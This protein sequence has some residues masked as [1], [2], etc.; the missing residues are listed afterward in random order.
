MENKII[1]ITN[2]PLGSD[3][4][5]E[6]T[7]CLIGEELGAEVK[8]MSPED[9]NE[10]PGGLLVLCSDVAV[11]DPALLKRMAQY[12][13]AGSHLI[14]YKPTNQEINTVYRALE[15]RD[16]FSAQ[17]KV[18]GYSL[19]GL[20]L[21]QGRTC[22]ILEGH[23]K[24]SS[25]IARSILDF[26][27]NQI[28]LTPELRESFLGKAREILTQ[29]SGVNLAEMARQYVLTN[30]FTL[31]GKSMSLSYFMTSCHNYDGTDP[32][33]GDD[34]YFIQQTGILNGQNGYEKYWA[35]TRVKVNGGSWYVGQGEVCLNY[36]DYYKMVNTP[37]AQSDSSGLSQHPVA[38]VYAQP[39]SINGQTQ[40]TIS[41]S[42]SL[43]G[44]LGFEGGAD[45]GSL[46]LKGNG[47]LSAGGS[48]DSSYTFTTEDCTCKGTSLDSQQP[49]ASWNYSFKRAS[50]NRSAGHWQRLH[51]PANLAVSVFSPVNTWVWK[52][53]TSCRDQ[54]K[55]FNSTFELGI[56]NTITRYSGSQGPKHIP[57]SLSKE[58][59]QKSMDITL[60]LPPLLAVDQHQLTFSKNCSTKTLSIACQGSWTL[61][62]PT[63]ASW[64]S[65]GD[66][67]T[68]GSGPDT[69]IHIT[70]QE[71]TGSHSRSAILTLCRN[72]ERAADQELLEIKIF[73]S[74]GSVE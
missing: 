73:Q 33:G 64:I 8:I 57:Q 14:L 1:T 35:G 58:D 5:I 25:Q 10:I 21:E 17:A 67:E 2:D 52:I 3:S 61:Q 56:M 74:P 54:F 50:Q 66:E 4:V 19:F 34:W 43:S 41:E 65:L 15:G 9:G 60:H 62:V 53:P 32:N 42:V 30:A 39:E 28:A 45:G 46:G 71:L 37:T 12:Y 68:S 51:P 59:S 69:V 13:F 7:M 47:S 6:E 70:V 24:E 23:Q 72:R 22:H 16:Y 31:F 36:I 11:D 63:D 48:F 27:Q 38:L 20:F 44:S 29:E 26:L 49:S 40:Y 18:S 55:S